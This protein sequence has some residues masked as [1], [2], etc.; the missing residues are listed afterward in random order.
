MLIYLFT[1]DFLRGHNK[2]IKILILIIILGA[3]VLTMYQ[4][5]LIETG[6]IV[7]RYAYQQGGISSLLFRNR[8]KVL[9][10]FDEIYSQVSIAQKVFGMGITEWGY[11][12]AEYAQEYW[13][14][15]WKIAEMDPIDMLL[16]NGILGFLLLYGY[17]IVRSRQAFIIY[18]TGLIFGIDFCL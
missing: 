2:S 8:D 18:K 11:L 7:Y 3:L 4:T 5:E 9:V 15:R 16:A 13:Q 6:V 14:N 12:F 17:Y 10:R 1:K